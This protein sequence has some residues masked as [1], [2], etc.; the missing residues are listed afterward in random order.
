VAQ[1]QPRGRIRRRHTAVAAIGPHDRG[2][3][4]RQDL[5]LLGSSVRGLDD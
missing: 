4:R 2:R 5:E 3:R 1:D